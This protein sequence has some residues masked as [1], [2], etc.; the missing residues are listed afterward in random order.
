MKRRQLVTELS[1]T[2]NIMMPMLLLLATGWILRKTGILDGDMPSRLNRLIFKILLPVL[3]FNNLRNMDR[4]AAADLKYLLF[5]FA[6]LTAVF[7]ISMAVVPRFEKNVRKQ[8]VMVQGIFRSNF[9]ILGVPLMDAMFGQAGNLVYSLALPVVIPLNNIL[10]VIALSSAEGKKADRRKIVK[11][12]LTNPLIIGC[13]AGAVF[14]FSGIS[15][16]TVIDN[17]FSKLADITSTL[18]LI[19]LGAS[20]K[21]EGIL[22]NR[23]QLLWTVLLKQAL[24]PAI[25]MA[26]AIMLGFTGPQMG[27]IIVLFGAPC[28]V[29]SFPMADAMGGD[30]HLAAGQVVLTTVAS[31]GTL[32]VMIL[33]GK[34]LQLI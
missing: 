15:L 10:A 13:A 33:A 5:L 30:S 16:P 29:S 19:V 24:I 26:A 3:L 4:K 20:L 6:G 11:D 31:M 27:V 14:Y 9:A 32:F 23:T 22:D 28:A 25:M 17:T 7:L 34:L 2:F 21:W 1:V 8:G 12:I 18:S